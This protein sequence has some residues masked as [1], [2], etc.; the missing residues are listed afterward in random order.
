MVTAET[1]VALPSLMLVLAMALGAVEAVA[2][3]VACTD[4]ARIGARALARGDDPE[5]ARALARRV[6]PASAQVELDLDAV[7]A[8]VEVSAPVSLGNVEVLT[9][10]ARA[11]TPREPGT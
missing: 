6:A 9:V 2:T 5:S 4:A 8:H 3:H 7:D 10:G 11:T 1:A